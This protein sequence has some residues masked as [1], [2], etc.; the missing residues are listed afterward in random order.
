MI[1]ANPG[2]PAAVRSESQ[3][4]RNSKEEFKSSVLKSGKG[5]SEEVVRLV[6]L[7]SGSEFRPGG[8][9]EREEIWPKL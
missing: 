1:R 8:K 4:G 7:Y 9:R 6:V 3:E 2:P 5:G